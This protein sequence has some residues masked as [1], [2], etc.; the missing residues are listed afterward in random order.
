MAIQQCLKASG[1]IDKIKG[2]KDKVNVDKYKS[3]GCKALINKRVTNVKIVLD[4]INDI[5]NI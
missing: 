2:S 5:I 3:I 4:Y 1:L